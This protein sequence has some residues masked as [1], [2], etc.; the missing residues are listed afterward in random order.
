MKYIKKKT[1]TEKDYDDIQFLPYEDQIEIFKERALTLYELKKIELNPERYKSKKNI[2]NVY[3]TR[4][5]K[6]NE[7]I[8]EAE[9]IKEVRQKLRPRI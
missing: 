9:K 7:L 8:E 5:R 3:N 4:S 6:K 2:Q 1:L